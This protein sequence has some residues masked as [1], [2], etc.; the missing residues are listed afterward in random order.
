[1][2]GF[3]HV[4]AYKYRIHPSDNI[5]ATAVPHT[6]MQLHMYIHTNTHIHMQLELCYA[7]PFGS[8][9]DPVNYAGMVAQDIMDGFVDSATVSSLMHT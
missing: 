6:Q 2:S 1:M 3:M 4:F 5:T 7:P 9:K 8:A